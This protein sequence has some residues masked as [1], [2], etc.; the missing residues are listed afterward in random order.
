M[1]TEEYA[2]RP[3]MMANDDLYGRWAYNKIV[4]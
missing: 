2:L 4:I 1:L 3:K